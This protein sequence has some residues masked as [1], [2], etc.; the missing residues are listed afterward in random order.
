[1][2][3][4]Y[5]VAA[6]TDNDI[7]VYTLKSGLISNINSENLLYKLCQVFKSAKLSESN[8]KSWPCQL[9]SHYLT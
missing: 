2:S 9:R 1:M 4:K 5:S 6:F 3:F 7:A 8:T